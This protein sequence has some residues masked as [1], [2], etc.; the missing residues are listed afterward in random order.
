[1]K[2]TGPALFVALL[3]SWPAIQHGLLDGTLSTPE[4]LVRV[5]IA[6]A[7]AMIGRAFLAGVVNHYRLHN[8]LHKERD[9]QATVPRA[10]DEA[11]QGS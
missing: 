6:L 1:M 3:L 8:L 5:G 10:E 9:E 4:M 11:R 2:L 7:L